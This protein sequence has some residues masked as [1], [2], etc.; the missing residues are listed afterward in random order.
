M[1]KGY[2]DEKQWK[3]SLPTYSVSYMDIK[4]SQVMLM[5]YTEL[6]KGGSVIAYVLNLEIK[7]ND[8]MSHDPG[9]LIF[10]A[11]SYHFWFHSHRHFNRG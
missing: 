1:I 9:I 11:C 2:V 6:G 10:Q 3:I 5:D 8:G 7:G 4:G